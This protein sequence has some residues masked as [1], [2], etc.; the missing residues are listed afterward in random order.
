MSHRSLDTF[1]STRT[2]STRAGTGTQTPV[3]TRL[4]QREDEEHDYDQ[5][6]DSAQ[7]PPP[8]TI[9][10]HVCPECATD[11]HLVVD[12]DETYCEACGLIVARDDLDRTLRWVDTDDGREPDRGGAPT[13]TRLH[14]KGLSTEIGHY[15]DGYGR[16]LSSQTQRRF[17]RLRKWNNQSKTDSKRARSL[18]TGL[19]EVARLV[20]ALELSDSIH[21]RAADI[22]REAWTAELLTG[23]SIEA[24]ATASVFAACRLERLPR[25]L[26]EIAEV[27]RVDV[28]D[29]NRAYKRMNQDL[30]L[31]T[32]PPLPQ[33]FL[34][35][36]ASAVDA[37]SRIERRAYQLVTSPSVG[38]LANGRQPSSV[39]AACLYHAYQEGGK[40]NVRITQRVLAEEGY[41]TA[42]TIRNIWKE[43]KALAETGD[44]PDPD[45]NLEDYS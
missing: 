16:Q 14:D 28:H 8:K 21:D 41:T 40:S 2:E 3:S 22:Y 25:H 35:R 9:T 29:I 10:E 5:K 17:S 24:L 12:G 26:D 23:R 1:D 6:R 11:E 32:P 7:P 19:G 4:R 37:S 36:I 43:L 13:T 18:R 31:A 30:E 45:G 15:C 34:P 27:A 20:S 39:A 33:D 42:T 44:L 38:I